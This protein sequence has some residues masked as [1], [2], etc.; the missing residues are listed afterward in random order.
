VDKEQLSLGK[1]PLAYKVDISLQRSQ[2]LKVDSLT[3]LVND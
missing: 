2:L 3:T 1:E